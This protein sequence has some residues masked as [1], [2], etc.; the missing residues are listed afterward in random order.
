MNRP[1]KFRICYTAQNGQK[2]LIYS[3]DKRYLIT[4]D[5]KVLE[6]YGKDWKNPFWEEVF[7]AD[8][9]PIIQQYTGLTDKNNIEVYDGDIVKINRCYTRPFVNEKQQ[10]D[11]KF[12]DDGEVEVGKVLWGWNTQKY[13]VSYEHIRYDDIEDFDK[14]SHRVEV[15][16]NIFEH[17]HLLLK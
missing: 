16:G 6:N 1:I 12:I 7:D 13:L 8:E 9:Q 15:I 10:I 14:P 2:S 5:G 4:L 11:Y 17:K 3:D